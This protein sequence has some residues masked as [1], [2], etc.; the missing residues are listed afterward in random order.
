MAASRAQPLA[1]PPRVLLGQR[2]SQPEALS[3]SSVSLR[4][5]AAAQGG[6]V[7]HATLEAA[8]ACSPLRIARTIFFAQGSAAPAPAPA[9]AAAAGGG[10]AGALPAGAACCSGACADQQQQQLL[11]QQEGPPSPSAE[12]PGGDYE[13]DRQDLSDLM[14]W[15]WAA[16]GAAWQCMEAYATHVS[17]VAAVCARQPALPRAC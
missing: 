5:Q 4:S 8:D 1:L 11:Q 2:T 16:V 3:S 12:L 10:A 15:Y 14:H 6:A 17:R 13:P 7:L 9:P